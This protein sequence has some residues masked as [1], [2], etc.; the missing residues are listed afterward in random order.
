MA[1]EQHA[2]GAPK[3]V[4]KVRSEGSRR[5]R[6]A[7]AQPQREVKGGPP[8]ALGDPRPD[9]P[10]AASGTHH[11]DRE[12][13]LGHLLLEGTSVPALAS[14]RRDIVVREQRDPGGQLWH[15]LQ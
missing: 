7:S 2:S 10:R 12:A 4:P 15:R 6:Q 3:S 5:L 8:S 14:D 13:D 11:V 9:A 1:E